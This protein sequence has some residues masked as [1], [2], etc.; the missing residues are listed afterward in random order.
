MELNKIQ[1]IKDEL[2]GKRVLCRVDFNVPVKESG[3]VMSDFRIK[4]VLPTINF[5]KDAGAKIILISHIGREPEET[6]LPVANYLNQN[7][8]LRVKFMSGIFGENIEKTIDEMKEGEIVMLENLRSDEGEVENLPLFA[9]ML[10][11]YGDVYVNDAF[12]VSHRDHA[13]ITGVPKHLPAFAGLRIQ[14]EIKNLSIENAA[15]PFLAV[16]AGK[17]FETKAPLIEKFLETADMVYVGGALVHD[18]YS[19]LGYEIGR[20]LHGEPADMKIVENEKLHFPKDVLVENG[21]RDSYKNATEVLNNEM[22]VDIGNESLEELKEFSKKAK[23]IIWNGPLGKRKTGTESYLNFL[24][25]QGSQIILGGGDTVELVDKMGLIN[26][27]SF[28]STGGGA[29]LEFLEKETLA[30]LSFLEKK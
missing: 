9:K 12:S 6:L 11:E 1:D 25:D 5:L 7:L 28:V 18:I 8:G 10:S 13:S 14:E 30:A 20:S 16:L 21:A 26:K 3:I 15:E 23:T 27:F 24:A 17:K 22:I 29:M 2:K 19:A 4:A